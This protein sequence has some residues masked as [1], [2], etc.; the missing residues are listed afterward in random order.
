VM[1]ASTVQ[2]AAALGKLSRP[3]MTSLHC[4]PSQGE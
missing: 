3:V 4:S 1:Q 2:M